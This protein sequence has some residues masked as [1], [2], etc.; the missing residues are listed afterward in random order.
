MFFF[1]KERIFF[2][3]K[4]DILNPNSIELSVDRLH[5]VYKPLGIECISIFLRQ[6]LY[7]S[8]DSTRDP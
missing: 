6:I 3:F 1:E 8:S 5:G 2:S 4:V 7:L